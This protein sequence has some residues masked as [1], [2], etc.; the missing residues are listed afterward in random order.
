MIYVGIDVASEKHDFFIMNSNGE[1]YTS[2]SVTIPNTDEGYKKL[3]KSI[4]EFCGASND[5]Q[6]RI[7]LESTGFYHRNILAF[8]LEKEY[9]LMVINPILTN[10]Y[11]KSIKVHIAKNDN[12]DSMYICKF[13]QSPDTVFTPY[14]LISYHSEAL[15][16]LS[17][18]RFSLVDELRL[19]KINI[20]KLISQVF[21]EY[22]KLFSN[23][24]QGT[25]LTI[26]EKYN[27]PEKLSRAHTDS[28]SS[29]IHGKCSTTAVDIITAAK[30]SVGIKSEHLSFQLKQAI[31][32]LKNI[33]A[34]I[35]EY[36]E[37]IKHYVDLININI[38]T[39]PGISYITAGLILGE[40]G[41]IARFKNADHLVSFAGLDV[42]V[43]ESGKY[44]AKNLSISKKGSKYLRYALYQ[45]AKVCWIYDPMFNKY[46]LKKKA[47]KKHYYV[48]L[49]HLEKKLIK[50]IY[51][52]LKDKDKKKTYSPQI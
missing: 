29:M 41:D 22:L 17:R 44:K 4:Q 14:T 9:S 42:M 19:A 1:L 6:V 52:I 30:Y 38:L 34:E 47:E 3:H 13:L 51:S 45:A 43:Y 15:K 20:Y 8:L 39:I 2:H 49:G 7:G 35:E 46:Y 31:N 10:M 27:N 40:I 5:Y 23:I 11:K 32:R 37:Q 21:P 18:E 33:S 36:N 24:Y 48:I 12:L 50:V 28:L 26:L 25:A 16:S